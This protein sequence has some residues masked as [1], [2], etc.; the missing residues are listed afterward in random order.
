MRQV[1]KKGLP[2]YLDGEL[3]LYR[4][5]I[6]FNGESYVGQLQATGKKIKYEQLSIYDKTKLMANENGVELTLKLRMPSTDFNEV[7]FV[8]IKEDFH[9]I[10][11]VTEIIDSRDG[12]KK[13]E[14]TL[15]KYTPIFNEIIHLIAK[16]Y[17]T[18][19]IGCRIETEVSRK[20]YAE[21]KKAESREHTQYDIGLRTSYEFMLLKLNYNGE[22][23]IEYGGRRYAV[24][25]T[26]ELKD[27][28]I[29]LITEVKKGDA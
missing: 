11:N 13:R 15:M 23:V 25:G 28:N 12:F 21:L 26:R 9:E 18:D 24:I 29:I 22:S 4:M 8:K 17:I 19:E 7:Y 3:E 1:F 2:K 6:I 16:T 5:A 20:V 10:S 27:N 14:L